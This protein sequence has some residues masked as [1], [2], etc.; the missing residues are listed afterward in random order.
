MMLMSCRGGA[1]LLPSRDLVLVDREDGGHL[2]VNPPRNVWERSELAPDELRDW[3]YLVAATGAAMLSQLKQLES[4][5]LNYWDA[6][7]WGLNVDAPPSGPK[8]GREHRQVHMHLFG[9]SPTAKSPHWC[10]GEAPLFPPYSKRKAWAEAHRRLTPQEVSSVLQATIEVL[11]RKYKFRTN[12]ILRHPVCT[13]CSYP[14]ATLG[15]SPSTCP[16]CRA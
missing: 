3:A 8:R 4:G 15:A 12:E 1:I 9:R 11:R 14:S 13:G 16:E 6:G 7:N 5:C 10:W 2:I